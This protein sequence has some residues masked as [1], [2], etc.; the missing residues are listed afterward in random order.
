MCA[1]E[2]SLYPLLVRLVAPLVGVS[3]LASLT[4]I[5]ELVWA[6]LFAQSLHPADLL[7]ALPDLEAAGARQVCHRPSPTVASRR[8]TGVAVASSANRTQSPA[9]SRTV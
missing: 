8:A 2:L 7:R 1:P 9:R 4:A 5:A 6:L 3:H